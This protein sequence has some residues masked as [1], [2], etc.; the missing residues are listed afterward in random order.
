MIEPVILGNCTLY[1]GDCLEVMQQRPD[2]SVDA[3]I[4]D[5]P[6]G[7]NTKSSFKGKTG[8][9]NP[10]ADL[11]NS[12]YWYS[13]WMTECLRVAKDNGCMWTFLNWRSLVTYQKASFDIGSPIESLL[14]W[15]KKWIG[16]GGQRG[17]RPSYEMVALFTN[18]EFFIADRGIPDIK[19]FMW[20]SKKPTGHPAEKPVALM[21][22]LMEISNDGGTTIL[23][24]FMGSGTTG[25]ACV[26]T[27]RK[28]IGC[29][30]EPKYFDIAVERIKDEQLHMRLET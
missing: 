20:T 13:A 12:A 17:L 16:P 1:L 23:D 18:Q 4:T 7:L 26:Q 5:P 9:L 28:F 15:D 19:A 22:W 6:Y 11:C 24:P 29:E 8:K 2:K 10:W 25:V 30:I 21:K 3:V 27:G 14:I